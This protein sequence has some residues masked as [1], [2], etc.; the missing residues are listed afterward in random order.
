MKLA[1]AREKARAIMSGVAEGADPVAEK[2]A[3][4]AAMTL[5]Q[6]FEERC[7]LDKDTAPRTLDD[8]RMALEKDVFPELGDRPANDIKPEEFAAVLEGVEARAKHAAHKVR[9]ALGAT[10]RWGQTQWRGGRRL[11]VVNPVAGIGFM[12]QSRPRKRVL[13]DTELG[14]LWRAIDTTE[15]VT[16]PVRDIVRLAILTGQRNSEIAG[17]EL[18]ELKG[19]DTE[20]PRWDIPARRMK[21]KSDDQYVPLA[22]QAVAIFR[23]AIERAAGSAYVFPGVTQGRRRGKEWR[24]EHVGQETVSRAFPKL[25]KSAGL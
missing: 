19:L 11:V 3:R 1:I 18:A 23:R 17:T 8:Y 6:L 14:K 20:T 22:P 5:R 13:S 2:V 9:S 12:H 21:R 25:A 10:Y 24:Q 7:R 15:S 16:E 4:E